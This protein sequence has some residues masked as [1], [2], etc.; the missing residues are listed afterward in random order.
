MSINNVYGLMNKKYYSL[1]MYQADAGYVEDFS[2][3]LAV[4]NYDSNLITQSAKV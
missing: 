4:P 1:P 3:I 2:R